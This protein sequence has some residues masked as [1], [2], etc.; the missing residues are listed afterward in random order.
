M[1]VGKTTLAKAL[2]SKLSTRL[3]FLQ[4]YSNVSKNKNNTNTQT[5]KESQHLENSSSSELSNTSPLIIYD[6]LQCLTI[7]SNQLFSRWFSE[8]SKSIQKLFEIIREKAQIPGNFVCV[9][10]DE[11]ESLAMCRKHS[12]ESGS[13]E[14]TDSIRVHVN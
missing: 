14:P 11:I 6:R 13:S 1:C 7:N 2:V 9:L 4:N 8:S 3:Y 5:T 12:S 10:I